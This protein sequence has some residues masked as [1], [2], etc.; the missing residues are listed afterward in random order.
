MSRVCVCVC[1]CVCVSVCLSV[2]LSQGERGKILVDPQNGYFL[3]IKDLSIYCGDITS[4]FMSIV[5]L[6]PNK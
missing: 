1:V 5:I 3:E 6:D 4:M 2:C